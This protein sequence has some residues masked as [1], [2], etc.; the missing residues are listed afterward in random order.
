MTTICILFASS[1]PIDKMVAV[2]VPW[3]PLAIL[4]LLLPMLL[5]VL[6][7]LL[8][9]S[10]CCCC[11]PS[12]GRPC[13]RRCGCCCCCAVAVAVSR[14]LL[15][16]DPRRSVYCCVGIGTWILLR[17]NALKQNLCYESHKHSQ[18]TKCHLFLLPPNVS[19]LLSCPIENVVDRL[20][21]YSSDLCARGFSLGARRVEAKNICVR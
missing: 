12:Y 8:L 6:L 18:R 1:D 4:L 2:V 13:S 21:P 20:L 14:S 15:L 7:V 11:C 5:L 16:G 3:H 17:C 19:Y 9:H 10:C